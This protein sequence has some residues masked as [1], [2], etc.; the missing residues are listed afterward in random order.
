M[1]LPQAVLTSFALMTVAVMTLGFSP[2]SEAD[3]NGPWQISAG[4]NQTAWR[5]NTETGATW[6]CTTLAG[7]SKPGCQPATD[8][9]PKN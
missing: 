7:A 6:F 4:G 5:I 8:L 9:P 1:T 2:R 3:R